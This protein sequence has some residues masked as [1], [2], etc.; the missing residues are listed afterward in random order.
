[1]PPLDLPPPQRIR[2]LQEFIGRADDPAKALDFLL[3]LLDPEKDADLLDY[4]AEN[5]IP[6]SAIPSP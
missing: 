5:P 3:D 1:M 2:A 6:Q 4:L